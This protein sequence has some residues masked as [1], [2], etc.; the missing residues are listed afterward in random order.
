MVPAALL[1]GLGEHVTQGGPDPQVS[2]SDDQTGCLHAPVAQGTQ[3]GRP[4]GLRFPMSGL[5]GHQDLTTIGQARY[6]HQ[7]GRFFFLQAGLDIYSVHP[8]VDHLQAREGAT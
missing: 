7:E 4:G 2:I 3:Y 8:E 5:Q 6:R 1:F